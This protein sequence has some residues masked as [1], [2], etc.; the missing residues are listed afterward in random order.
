[1]FQEN[2][3]AVSPATLIITADA[4]Q[5]KVYGQADPVFTYTVD[6][7]QHND[8]ETLLQGTL[9]RETGEEVGEYQLL[10]GTL[11]AGNN[12]S[13]IYNGDYFRI[14]AGAASA[15][16]STLEVSPATAGEPVRITVTVR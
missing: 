15:A 8:D 4:S 14:T 10:Q 7:L 2:Y 6:G 12:Y 5:Q 13:L 16:G 9:S 1:V 11:T 3:F